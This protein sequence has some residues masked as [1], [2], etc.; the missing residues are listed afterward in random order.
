M[1]TPITV[2][3]TGTRQSILSVEQAGAAWDVLIDTGLNPN[4]FM[5]M[6]AMIESDGTIR[7]HFKN[8]ETRQYLTITI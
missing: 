5:Q 2:D 4:D 7:V 1:T 8:I 3:R 6:H